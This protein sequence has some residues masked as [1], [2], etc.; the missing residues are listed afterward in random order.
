MSKIFTPTNQ[1]RL[2]NVAVVRLKKAGKRFEIAC[3]KNKVVEFRDGIEKNI[4]EVLQTS[5]VFTNVS[6]G[7]LAKKDDLVS[8]FGTSDESSISLEILNKGELQVSEQE[9]QSQYAEMFTQIARIV[10]EKCVEPQ[11]QNHYP[12]TAI[13]KVMKQLHY[14]VNPTKNAKKQALDVIKLN[15]R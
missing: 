13:E 6:K 14:N 12:P 4:Q 7:Q 2:T 10:S 9:R 3:Y 5:N 15:G 1:R 8:A 11:T